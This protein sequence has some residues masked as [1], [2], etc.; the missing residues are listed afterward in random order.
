MIM[1]VP[2]PMD[3]SDLL[4]TFKKYRRIYY[5]K[6][7]LPMPADVEVSFCDFA[8]WRPVVDEDAIPEACAT[9][10]DGQ[11]QIN[12]KPYLAHLYSATKAALLH[13]MAHISI[14]LRPN[15]DRRR[16]GH[17]KTF[18]DEIDRLYSLGAY[19]KIL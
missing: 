10:A 1:L 2:S 7:G 17:G 19:R 5:V 8:D 4:W 15:F 14:D 9:S 3:D 11:Y 18:D 16:R 6:Y 12:I 13:E